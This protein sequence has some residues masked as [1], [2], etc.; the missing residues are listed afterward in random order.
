VV[1]RHKYITYHNSS[2]RRIIAGA[3]AVALTE[4]SHIQI[5]ID[6]VASDLRRMSLEDI[7]GRVSESF[8]IGS[9]Y[10]CNN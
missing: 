5:R 7:N 8:D 9:Y 6:K 10:E 2:R 1:L 4:S 3:T